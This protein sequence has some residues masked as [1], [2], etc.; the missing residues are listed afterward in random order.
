MALTEIALDPHELVDRLDEMLCWMAISSEG[1]KLSYD[2]SQFHRAVPFIGVGNGELAELTPTSAMADGML[3][4][5]ESLVYGGK[6]V[7]KLMATR[8][9][10]EMKRLSYAEITEHA[11]MDE[12]SMQM[13]FGGKSGGDD[14]D[15]LT[16]TREGGEK[17]YVGCR[18]KLRSIS[19]ETEAERKWYT[20]RFR[21]PQIARVIRIQQIISFC[22]GRSIA[23]MSWLAAWGGSLFDLARRPLGFVVSDTGDS[24][25]PE[26]VFLCA[27]YGEHVAHRDS[28]TVE[29][30]LNK[31]RTGVG[32]KTDALG[33]REF[34]N[35]IRGSDTKSGRRKSLVHWVDEHMR[36]KNRLDAEA[37]VAVA[38]HLRGM[39]GIE[40]G[41]HYARVWP[42]P[43]DIAR[44]KNGQRFGGAAQGSKL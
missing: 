7:A 28:W 21:L 41:S 20:R 32:L 27:A 5:E 33:A 40:A 26:V 43:S 22:D 4:A 38:G 1:H 6:D 29:L 12:V 16:I 8:G 17:F 30:S 18:Y 31:R 35:M 24:F 34:V 42:S 2:A 23:E 3:S 10:Q 15:D 25:S 14:V 44:A 11:E 36:R 39:A 9:L 37:T 13:Q 19:D